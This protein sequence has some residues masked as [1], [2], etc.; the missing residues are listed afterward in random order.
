MDEF[1]KRFEVVYGAIIVMAVVALAG[2]ATIILK[3]LGV[4]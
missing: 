3:I 2:A 1:D 4:F